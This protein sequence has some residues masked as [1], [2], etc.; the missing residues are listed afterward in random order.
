MPGLAMKTNSLIISCLLVLGFIQSL[1]SPPP[2]GK[3]HSFSSSNLNSGTPSIWLVHLRYEAQDIPVPLVMKPTQ[4]FGPIFQPEAFEGGERSLLFLF[5][6]I[7]LF[8]VIPFSWASYAFYQWL[9]PRMP[10]KIRA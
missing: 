3:N 9:K 6:S 10:R 7:L 5:S 8:I 2:N 1:A 4:K